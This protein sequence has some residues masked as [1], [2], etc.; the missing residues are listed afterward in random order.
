VVPTG[1]PGAGRTRAVNRRRRRPESSWACRAHGWRNTRDRS[2]I[3][4]TGR[5]HD[6]G[7]DCWTGTGIQGQRDHAP[8]CSG[9]TIEARRLNSLEADRVEGGWLECRWL[10]HEGRR[11]HVVHLGVPSV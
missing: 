6:Q 11:P 2:A 5:G 4:A 9:R 10:R 7:R 1:R 8:G 3:Q